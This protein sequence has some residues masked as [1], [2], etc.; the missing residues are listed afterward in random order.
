[1]LPFCLPNSPLQLCVELAECWMRLAPKLMS[2]MQLHGEGV[3]RLPGRLLA[4]I[5]CHITNQSWN[6]HPPMFACLRACV[7]ACVPARMRA[8]PPHAP[9][10][11]PQTDPPRRA[12]MHGAGPALLPLEDPTAA[13]SLMAALMLLAALDSHG[14]PETLLQHAI[15][16]LCVRQVA[17]G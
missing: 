7:L 13:G 12:A 17:A 2:K 9:S 16:A 3:A 1:M 11:P 15:K 6:I 14:L 8:C 10:D 4:A 5:S